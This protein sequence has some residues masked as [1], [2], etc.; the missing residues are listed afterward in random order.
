MTGPFAP[1]L[2]DPTTI[3]G[4]A[5]LGVGGTL[6]VVIFYF[7][8]H[9]NVEREKRD[10][11]EKQQRELANV[12]GRENGKQREDRLLAVVERNAIAG[13]KLAGSVD[14]LKDWLENGYSKPVR[15]A[16]AA[17]RKRA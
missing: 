4:W 9:D 3:P 16:K 14:G 8:R 7:W 2:Q 5:S 13:E 6:A 10:Q 1:L 11:A 12:A 15:R 17:R